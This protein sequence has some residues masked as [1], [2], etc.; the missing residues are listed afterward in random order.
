MHTERRRERLIQVARARQQGA[1]VLQDIHD[2]HNA[3]AVF[4]SADALGFQ[5]ICLI[6]ERGEP[7]DP[8]RIGKVSSASANKWLD[9]ETYSGTEQCLEQLRAEGYETVAT[10][11]DPEAESIFGAE[12]KRPRTAL[13]FGN[14]HRGLSEQAVALADRRLRIPMPGMVESLNLSVTAAICLYELTRQRRARG[15]A[16]Y[17][18][19]EEQQQALVDDFLKRGS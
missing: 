16:E 9:F 7:F 2:P 17:L 14:E 18:Y 19:P 15:A 11:L 13:L 3:E 5:R 8:R 1:I 6:F 12:L 4:R 10:V